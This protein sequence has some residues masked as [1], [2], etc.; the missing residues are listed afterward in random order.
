MEGLLNKF[1]QQSPVIRLWEHLED[2]LERA[3]T[4]AEKPA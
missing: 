1:T 3:E 2:A 4:E